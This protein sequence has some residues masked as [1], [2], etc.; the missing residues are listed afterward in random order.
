MKTR[1]H[2]LAL[3][4]VA[5]VVGLLFLQEPGF[6]D[7]LT[8]W[9]FAFD[10]H[11]RG[12]VAWQKGSFHDLRWPVWGVCWVLQSIFGFGLTSYYGVPL[13]YLAGGAALGFGFGK[14]LTN[15]VAIAWACGIAFLFHPLL[16]TVCYRP[17]PDL[18]EGVWGA[19]IMFAWWALMNAPSRGVALLAAAA[20]GAGIFVIEANRVTGVFIVPVVILCTLLF[21]PRRFGWLLVAGLVSAAL[22]A[23][24]CFFYKRLFNDWLH[25]LT[26]NSGNKGA[27]GTEFP[28]PWSLPFRFFDTLWKGNPL[29]PAYCLLALGGIRTAWRRHGVLGRVIVVWF[30][31]LY[32]LYACAPQSLWPY[33]PLVRDADRFLAALV[34]PMS[35]LA[36]LGLRA[37]GAWLAGRFLFVRE[38]GR[39]PVVTGAFLTSLLFS[40]TSR[41][42]FD[43]GFVPEMRRYLTAL[44]EGTKVF[45]HKAMREII[46]LVDAKSASRFAW[47][48]PNEIM[49]RSEKLEAQA[50]GC[51]EFWYA[52]KLVWLTTRKALEK[53]SLKQQAALG[54]YLDAPEREWMLAGLFA[55]ADNPDL[56]FYRRRQPDAPPAQVLGPDATE[57]QQLIPALPATMNKTTGTVAATWKIPASLKGKLARFE[58]EAASPQVE[59]LTM[60]LRFHAGESEDPKME[61]LLKPYLYSGGGKEFFVLP[62]PTDADTCQ[63][64]LKLS[65]DAKEVI[66]TSFRAVIETSE[67]RA[68]ARP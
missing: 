48:A 63:V 64:Q 62:I 33:R 54:S 4:A 37:S 20:T 3:I 43:L 56:V 41:N 59:A 67:G 19:A 46:F 49:H 55:K 29:A 15:S 30:A 12:L 23:G 47:T 6:G 44:P 66:F 10:L 42:H 57:W 18:S 9:S 51:T 24:E 65:K 25:D 14:K 53:K 17:M 27:K 16:D 13:L 5:F 11:E 32:L 35:V 40:I 38:A 39:R 34:V 58:F 52:R 68:P 2:L 31:A 22:Y 28:N 45:S 21:F 36:A 61:Y 26:A 8:Y 50:A 7:D 60:R 1:W